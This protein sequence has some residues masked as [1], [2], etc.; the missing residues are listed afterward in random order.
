M[1][2]TNLFA[3]V[4]LERLLPE[5]P[6]FF[7]SFEAVLAEILQ[8]AHRSGATEVRVV[9]NSET[10]SLIFID[11]GSGLESPDR[12]LKV[13]DAGWDEES[14]IDP[15]GMGAFATLRPEF[16]RQVVYE[17]H[18]AWNWRLTV[19]PDVLSG[20][21]AIL[22]QLSSNGWTGLSVALHLAPETA[23]L[24]FPDLLRRARG[25]YPFRL[26]YQDEHGQEQ[27]ITPN[28][29]WEPDLVLDLPEGHFQWHHSTWRYH[30]RKEAVWEYRP[31]DSGVVAEA[32]AEAA[33]NH[34]HPDLARALADDSHYRWFVNPACGVLPKLPDR[35]EILDD[36]AL[37]RAAANIV[38]ALVK[39]VLD[40]WSEIVVEWPDW[41]QLSDLG[42]PLYTPAECIWMAHEER[43][44]RH[45][46]PVLG[47][48]RVEYVEPASTH[49]YAMDEGD[50]AYL[51][52]EEEII[53]RYHREA[54]V[55]ASE[56]LSLS[57]NL[58]GRPTSRSKDAQ[59]PLVAIRGFRADPKLSPYVAL[60]EEVRVG[61]GMKVPWVLIPGMPEQLPWIPPDQASGYSGQVVIFSGSVQAFLKVLYEN[62]IFVNMIALEAIKEDFPD[63][64]QDWQDGEP[65]FDHDAARA[66][67][68]VQ[69]TEAFAP[70]LCR[71]RQRYYSLSRLARPL[72]EM[73]WRADVLASAIGRHAGDHRDLP[74]WCIQPAVR[75][76]QDSLSALRRLLSRY[77]RRLG[78][79]AAIPPFVE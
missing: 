42:R 18:G 4:N 40:I 71:I 25:F 6:R 7:P 54:A 26:L 67:I 38:E 49:W 5:I 56:A 1:T 52:R 36:S 44:A 77:L 58:Q 41:F 3:S 66:T 10:N 12:L 74:V 15:A 59:D 46:F 27:A 43:L 63:G 72:D 47:W 65:S 60:A 68:A 22:S 28:F 35:N 11:N 20:K 32:L 70:E 16:V 24:Y 9:R 62:P 19:T 76:I 37:R 8:N 75:L 64:W 48:K 34:V 23:D 13:G 21:P 69:V 61:E 78:R 73:I 50:G 14:V 39:R 2:D 55:V 45:L 29:E 30:R 33:R 17:S 31:I 79:I 53:I 51:E 57:L